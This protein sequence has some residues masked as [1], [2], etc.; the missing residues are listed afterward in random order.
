VQRPSALTSTAELI[1]V[2]GV[3]WFG[4]QLSNGYRFT[5]THRTPRVQVDVP[6]KYSPEVDAL[7]DLSGAMKSATTLVPAL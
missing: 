5:L 3:D 1:T 4:Q 6:A 7:V 2:N